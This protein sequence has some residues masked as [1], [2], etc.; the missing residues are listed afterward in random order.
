MSDITN[1]SKRRRGKRKR[2]P[3]GLLYHLKHKN[4]E[5][6]DVGGLLP[7]VAKALGEAMLVL[8]PP[9]KREEFRNARQSRDHRMVGKHN[10][11]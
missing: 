9:E 4:K 7:I 3:Y 1:V 5:F 8:L 6:N 10:V 11:S 2:L